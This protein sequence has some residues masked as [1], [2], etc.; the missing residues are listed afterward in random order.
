MW[1]TNWLSTYLAVFNQLPLSSLAPPKYN[2]TALNSRPFELKSGHGVL[3]PHDFI[4]LPRPGEGV[5]NPDGDLVFTP[6]SS[7][8]FKEK[9]YAQC[10]DTVWIRIEIFDTFQKYAAISHHVARFELSNF[11]SF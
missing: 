5:A 10:L 1:L 9:K 3:S 11:Y 2:M 8:S 4:Q 6:V 7:W